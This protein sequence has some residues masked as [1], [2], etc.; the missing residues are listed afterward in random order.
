MAK[1][2]PQ[3]NYFMRAK[4]LN[5]WYENLFIGIFLL[6]IIFTYFKIK[7]LGD[8]FSIIFIFVLGILKYLI[9]HYQ[10]KAEVIR[11]KDFIDNSFGTK[12]HNQSSI[13]YYDNEEIE[14]GLYKMMVNLFENSLFSKEVS[15][16]MKSKAMVHSIIPSIIVLGF[17]IFGFSRNQIALPILQLFLSQ[18]FI[19]KVI[20]IWEYNKKVENTF[21]KILNLFDSPKKIKEDIINYKPQILNI[22]V[23]YECNISNSNLFLDG[24][25]F[26]KLNPEL[27]KEWEDMKNRYKIN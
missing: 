19:L 27:T 24:K 9:K 16:K 12:L 2:S 23:E 15:D 20:I 21:N 22:L 10:E 6:S 5:K 4:N 25:I 18:L 14:K 7:I 1:S 11:R 8:I 3:T 26:D 17:A 13:E